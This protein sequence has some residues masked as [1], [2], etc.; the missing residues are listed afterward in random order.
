M[1]KSLVLLVL[2]ALLLS[3]CNKEISAADAKARA[4][5]IEE[6]EVDLSTIDAFKVEASMVQDVQGKYRGQ[7]VTGKNEIK[8]V[9][10]IST[11]ENF[12][13]VFHSSSDPKEAYESEHWIYLKDS[14]FFDVNRNKDDEGESKLY[15]KVEGVESVVTAAFE[16]AR[17]ALVASVIDEATGKS[18]LAQV[19][20]V[21]DDKP[22][23]GAK[24][25]VKYYSAGEGSLT[26]E[27]KVEYEGYTTNNIKF[28]S[29]H[30]EIKYAW[31]KYLLSEVSASAYLA[32]VASSVDTDLHID[33]KVSEKLAYE[34]K[35]AYPNLDD[36]K[37]SL[38]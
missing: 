14:V 37:Q 33:S 5:E 19:E 8:T 1:K 17:K 35:A 34:V 25:S 32:V 7:D 28:D 20:N 31:D 23:E 13:H 26:V 6:H 2:P 36:Y 38:L 16:A 3:G 12:F 4:K 10:E 15:S 27:G 24:Y 30:A 11:K 22:E 9:Y 18:Y 21:A 29:G